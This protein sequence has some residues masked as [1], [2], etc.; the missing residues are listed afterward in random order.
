MRWLYFLFI[1]DPYEEIVPEFFKSF[2]IFSIQET[3]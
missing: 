1:T 2:Y 3:E